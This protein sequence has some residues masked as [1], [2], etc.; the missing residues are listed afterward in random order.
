V[1]LAVGLRDGEFVGDTL[2]N[3][4]GDTVGSSVGDDVGDADGMRV[5]MCARKSVFFHCNSFKNIINGTQFKR[6]TVKWKETPT[7]FA[8]STLRGK[9]EKCNNSSPQALFD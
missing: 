2:G 5:L 8:E 4:V 3:L 9:L 7:G 6:R 1:G